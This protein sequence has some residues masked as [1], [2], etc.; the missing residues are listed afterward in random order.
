LAL[1]EVLLER[2]RETGHAM[3]SSQCDD[4]LGEL[5]IV[6]NY[7]AHGTTFPAHQQTGPSLASWIAKP[8]FTIRLI[9]LPVAQ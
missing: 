3:L 1:L 2:H 7:C 8:V 4:S 9:W 5:D 6:I